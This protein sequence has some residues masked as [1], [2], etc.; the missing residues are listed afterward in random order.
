MMGDQPDDHA[1]YGVN[2]TTGGEVCPS[3]ANQPAGGLGNKPKN[4]SR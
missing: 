4:M 3:R 2:S 1:N